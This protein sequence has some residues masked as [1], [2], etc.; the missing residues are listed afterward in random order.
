M[1]LCKSDRLYIWSFVYLLLRQGIITAISIII[2]LYTL[3]AHTLLGASKFTF[4]VVGF[5]RLAQYF[6][7][8]KYTSLL[9]LLY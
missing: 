1:V 7:K 5:K 9:I 2:V 4:A 3:H 8:N 6:Q